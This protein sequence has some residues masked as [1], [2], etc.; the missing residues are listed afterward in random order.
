MGTPPR[1]RPGAAS[2]F[3]TTDRPAT[4]TGLLHRPT[5]SSFAVKTAGPGRSSLAHD[6]IEERPSR[7]PATSSNATANN[8]GLGSRPMSASKERLMGQYSS[9]GKLAM[10]T[11]RA[12]PGGKE[13]R[14]DGAPG[15]ARRRPTTPRDLYDYNGRRIDPSARAA[16]AT[17]TT[18]EA[19]TPRSNRRELDDRD[20][21]GRAGGHATE[22]TRP[23][24]A[25]SARRRPSTARAASDKPE[26]DSDGRRITRDGRLRRDVEEPAASRGG[27]AT[28]IR[29]TRWGG[30][31][32]VPLKRAVDPRRPS[33]A[34]AGRGNRSARSTSSVLDRPA[35]DTGPGGLGIDHR[36]PARKN[37]TEK[38]KKTTKAGE[39]VT[40]SRRG[41]SYD[42]DDDDRKDKEDRMPSNTRGGGVDAAMDARARL[43]PTAGEDDDGDA[44]FRSR[45]RG[46]ATARSRVRTPSS[47][48]GLDAS[49]AMDAHI[50]HPRLA[51][52][53]RVGGGGVRS[54]REFGGG[55]RSAA[56]SAPTTPV[57]ASTAHDRHDNRHVSAEELV[58]SVRRATPT[59]IPTAAAPPSVYFDRRPNT[60]AEMT[61]NFAPGGGS[62]PS[63]A[64]ATPARPATSHGGYGRA[65]PVGIQWATDQPAQSASGTPGGGYGIGLDAAHAHYL[66]QMHQYHQ[67]HQY[68]QTQQMQQMQQPQ[69]QMQQHG[70][71]QPQPAHP[72]FQYHQQ[73]RQQFH[74][75]V[76]A[77]DDFQATLARAQAL[78]YAPSPSKLAASYGGQG[79]GFDA[80]SAQGG[81]QYH[82]PNYRNLPHQA[83]QQQASPGGFYPGGA[84]GVGGT[85]TGAAAAFQRYGGAF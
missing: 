46:P 78:A 5:S 82:N 84:Y 11:P 3:G 51:N 26:Y 28:T 41:G 83:Y 71:H 25:A 64:A 67:Y 75:P 37:R 60:R 17:T 85:A 18:R 15:S 9:L 33:T 24:T 72:G 79:F 59:A 69:Q 44:P 27:G 47:S 74:Q 29:K 34:T 43:L 36:D 70:Y 57:G 65:H 61:R 8:R 35:F 39:R 73:A 21:R 16:A 14:W 53:A 45:L 38:G 63:S 48:R 40:A 13:N 10:A 4:S 81:Y 30:F 55:Y 68:Q 52:A 20:S 23:S 80:G 54:S 12:A 66:Q 76:T 56:P 7:R 6:A 50:A 42:D 32:E 77:N 31:E 58:E 19:F 49:T 22:R 1:A 2:R 62:R